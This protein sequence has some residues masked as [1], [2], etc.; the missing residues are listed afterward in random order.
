MTREESK[1]INWK[2][3]HS[4]FTFSIGTIPRGGK[5]RFGQ[6]SALGSVL[7]GIQGSLVDVIFLI[8][9]FYPWRMKLE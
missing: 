1:V 7:F 3:D 4:R 9:L 2:L 8:S 6:L 5:L